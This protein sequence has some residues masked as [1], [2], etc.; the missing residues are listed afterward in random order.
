MVPRSGKS[1]WQTCEQSFAVMQ[2]RTD[3]TVHQRR[4]THDSSSEHFTDG[5]MPETNS[6]NRSRA[7]KVFYDPL[8]D[9]GLRRNARSGRNHNACRFYPIQFLDGDL[10]IAE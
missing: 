10:V 2:D 8:R 4:S 9:A 6:E 3:L 5:L 7:V 1:L